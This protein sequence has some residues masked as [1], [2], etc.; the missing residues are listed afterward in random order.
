MNP[1]RVFGLLG[2]LFLAGTSP[3][4][5]GSDGELVTGSPQLAQKNAVLPE[6]LAEVQRTSQDPDLESLIRVAGEGQSLRDRL[7]AIEVLARTNDVH[8]F[9]ALVSLLR[10]D[11]SWEV[12]RKAAGV[13]VEM[14]E[15]LPPESLQDKRAA[16]LVAPLIVALVSDPDQYVRSKAA[17][18]LGKMKS[19]S[20]LEPLQA[21]AR[22]DVNPVK[23]QAAWAFGEL[24]DVRAIPS[25]V[26]LLENS[27]R[28]VRNSAANSLIRIGRPAVL[29]LAQKLSAANSPFARARA[30]YVLGV[31]GDAEATGALINALG[32]EVDDVRR[33]AVNAL[34][35]LKGLNVVEGVFAATTHPDR[36]VR[37]GALTVWVEKQGELKQRLLIPLRKAN[38]AYRKGALWTVS[39]LSGSVSVDPIV[40]NALKN[41]NPHYREG[42]LWVLKEM[43]EE[44]VMDA[45]VR[46]L[47]HPH[48][49]IRAGAAYQLGTLRH[50]GAEAQLIPLL[51]DADPAVR[52][53]AAFA[54]RESRDA[55][56]MEPLIAV[57]SDAHGAVRI[58]AMRSLAKFSD[59]KLIEPLLVALNDKERD[60][61]EWAVR[62][63]GYH[64][65]ARVVP[66]LIPML[67]DPDHKVRQ[68]TMAALTALK[69]RRAVMPIVTALGD[70]VPLVRAQAA[71]ALGDFQDPGATEGLIRA[72]K[73][74]EESVQCKAAASLLLMDD[75]RAAKALQFALDDRNWMVL[76]CAYPFYLRLGKAGSEAVLEEVLARK[77]DWD[78]AAAFFRCGNP[79][80]EHAA[81]L[82]M[83]KRKHSPHARN[84]ALERADHPDNQIRW[85]V[86]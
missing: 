30:A 64:Q 57:L 31:I 45:F 73:D 6:T 1:C 83:E 81:F 85:G 80:L 34:V 37:E 60:V 55:R 53:Q 2:I 46:S 68:W 69:D 67:D 28:P 58:E 49:D 42:A 19:E 50:R 66:A 32:D 4:F 21:A 7:V 29:P 26:D 44:R 76:A 78:M 41:R 11:A 27:Y 16:K 54:L 72:L 38:V 86:P 82:W 14:A 47:E 71:Y 51:Q 59:A 77:G 22:D 79:T 18:L 17:F 84:R 13:L 61:R 56:I 33:E 74:P 25:L 65:D 63:L 9:Q 70:E 62:G 40:L 52:Q 12:R 20:A 3:S 43:K 8:T 10:E 48:A 24:G 39:G 75:P 5:G 15:R 23:L 36:N 35:Q